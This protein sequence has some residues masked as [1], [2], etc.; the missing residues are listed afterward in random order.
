MYQIHFSTLDEILCHPSNLPV[1]VDMSTAKK[2]ADRILDAGC[3]CCIWDKNGPIEYRS[4][5]IGRLL[6]TWPDQ[7]I[8]N[9]ESFKQYYQ[10]CL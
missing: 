5:T 9:S 8:V 7:R 1:S 4:Q 2:M 3:I 6:K 10:N